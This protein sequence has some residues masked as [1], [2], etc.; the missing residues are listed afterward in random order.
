MLKMTLWLF[1]GSQLPGSLSIRA[2]MLMGKTLEVKDSG[3]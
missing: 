1:L 3:S 2:A